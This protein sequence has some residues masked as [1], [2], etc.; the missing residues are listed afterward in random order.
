MPGER[1]LPSHRAEKEGVEG[2]GEEDRLL[3][4]SYVVKKFARSGLDEML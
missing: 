3:N 2:A 4:L 1:T